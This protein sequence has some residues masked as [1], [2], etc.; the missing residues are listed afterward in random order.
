M[1]TQV[2]SKLPQPTDASNRGDDGAILREN[3]QDTE[4]A[5]HLLSR[6]STDSPVADIGLTEGPA[7]GRRN[8]RDTFTVARK[9]SGTVELA[10]CA[11]P[12]GEA[13]RG[14]GQATAA[15]SVVATR[16]RLVD[17]EEGDFYRA[18]LSTHLSF[19]ATTAADD[20]DSVK[21]GTQTGSDL[22]DPGRSGAV[23]VGEAC[24]T[25]Q[26][27][28]AGVRQVNQMKYFSLTL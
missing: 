18:A 25:F 13:T 20:P 3:R 15:S 28:M 5:N 9:R 22:H 27:D 6:R 21:R 7:S 1:P 23:G 4:A 11:I 14:N 10:A 24:R 12:T 8:K 16:S 19:I 2:V 26:G 17:R